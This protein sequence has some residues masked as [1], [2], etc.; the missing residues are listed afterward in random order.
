MRN[1]LVKINYPSDF[2]EKYIKKI[3]FMIT[4]CDKNKNCDIEIGLQWFY[5]I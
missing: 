1:I 2:I 5:H 3:M 4:S